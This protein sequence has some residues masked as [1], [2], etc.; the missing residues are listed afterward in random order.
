[1]CRFI[2][3]QDFR[4]LGERHGDDDPLALPATQFVDDPAAEAGGIRQLH[5][6]HDRPPVV[7]PE[8]PQQ[9]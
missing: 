9:A 4:F 1:M 8:A 3:Q 2:Q 5:R 7:R 6:L